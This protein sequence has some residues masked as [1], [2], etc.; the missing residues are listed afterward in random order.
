MTDWLTSVRVTPRPSCEEALV[1]LKDAGLPTADLT[2]AHM[3]HFFSLG[4]DDAAIGLVGLELYGQ[5]ALLRSLVVVSQWRKSGLGSTLIAHAESHARAH[6]ATSLYL[7]TTDAHAYFSRYGFSAI[8]RK[9]APK[10]IRTTQEFAEICPTS[11]TLMVKQ[12]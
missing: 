1:L 7:L 4:F 8:Q 12:L 5:D 2:P 9:L 3:E 10:S 6:G 11:S